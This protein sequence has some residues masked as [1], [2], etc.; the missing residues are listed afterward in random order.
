MKKLLIIGSGGYIGR[1]LRKLFLKD[2]E[3]VLHELKNRKDLN[4]N[5]TE[6]VI[7]FFSKF[8]YDYIINLTGQYAN[9]ANDFASINSLG[10]INLVNALKKSGSKDTKIIFFSTTLVYGN[11]TKITS[12]KGVAKP[13]GNYALS[14]YEGEQILMKSKYNTLILR[15]AN[16]YDNK[17]LKKG[18]LKNIVESVDNKT[19]IKINNLKSYSNYIHINDLCK[20][21]YSLVKKNTQFTKKIINVGNENLSIKQIIFLFEEL[22]DINIKTSNAKYS[23]A[24]ISQ[25]ID[26]TNFNKTD[27]S[28]KKSLKET[29]ISFYEKKYI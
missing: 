26:V 18:L 3:Y 4:L 15:V 22:L 20:F 28:V 10:N 7:N 21:V 19:Q 2:S 11:T 8:Q 1:N 5:K 17:F 24:S 6:D 16:V 29:I 25:K 12:E 9:S 23:G 13:I 27:E 14:K